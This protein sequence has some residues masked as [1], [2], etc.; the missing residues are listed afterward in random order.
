MT[1][2]KVKVVFQCSTFFKLKTFQNFVDV[3]AIWRFSTITT[4]AFIR[5]FI[6]TP[7]KNLLVW[8][9]DLHCALKTHFHKL[10][11]HLIC[12]TEPSF[13]WTSYSLLPHFPTA[14]AGASSNQSS[15]KN[16]VIW[17]RTLPA[18]PASPSKSHWLLWRSFETLATIPTAES[19]FSSIKMSWLYWLIWSGLPTPNRLRRLCCRS[20][21]L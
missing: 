21:G 19:N 6:W 10:S 2:K 15:S 5:H 17:L 8:Y 18:I 1:F 9:L 16:W 3:T 7:K 4:I 12:R 20:S 13:A 14:R 11:Q